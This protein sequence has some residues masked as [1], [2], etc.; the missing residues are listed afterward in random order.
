MS[1]RGPVLLGEHVRAHL[2]NVIGTQPDDLPIEC[3]V[4]QSAQRQSVRDNWFTEKIG[5][6]DDV[7][8]VEQLFMT[9]ATEGTFTPICLQH[10]F[11]KRALVHPNSHLSGCVAPQDRIGL[12][13]GKF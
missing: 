1:Q 12:R 6:R 9:K 4:M 10:S 7:S 8:G 5:I 11:P 3:A 2:D 13:C